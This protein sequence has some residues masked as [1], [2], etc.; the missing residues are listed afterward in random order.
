MPPARRM[1]ASAPAAA[2]AAPPK[3]QPRPL[4]QTI[5][6]YDVHVSDSAADPAAAAWPGREPARVQ[7]RMD[8]FLRSVRQTH[9]GG[10]ESTAD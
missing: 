10:M 9:G 1:D 8:G 7:T 5:L 2:P 3:V 6:P 4:K